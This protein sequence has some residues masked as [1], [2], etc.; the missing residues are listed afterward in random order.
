MFDN[1]VFLREEKTLFFLN[2]ETETLEE[3]A[4]G[5]EQIKISPN[6]EKLSYI[7]NHEVWILFLKDTTLQKAGD[8]IFLHRF[9][10]NNIEGCYWLN[11]DYLIYN[12]GDYIKISE[13]DSR[14][15]INIIDIFSIKNPQLFWGENQE[16][17][18]ILSEKNLYVLENL[19][20]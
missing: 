6:R 14:D 17:L 2:P 18:Y 15:K 19:L 10:S 11:S 1:H 12:V 3:L 13:I 8:K 16:E 5:V 4:G 9:L 7:T 20:P